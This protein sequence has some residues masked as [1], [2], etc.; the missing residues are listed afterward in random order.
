MR[1]GEVPEWKKQKVEEVKQ[2]VKDKKVVGVFSLQ[3]LP[4]SQ[5]QSIRKQL[6]G[7]A[8]L[9]VTKKIFMQR[10]F[11]EL[12]RPDLEKLLQYLQGPCGLIV[13]EENPFKLF[14]IIKKSRSKAFAKPGMIAEEDIIVP[15]GETDLPVGPVLSE[16]K[17]AKIDCKIDK[18]KIVVNKDSVVTKKGEKVTEQAAAALSKLGIMPFKIGLKILALTEDGVIYTPEVLDINEEQVMSELVSSCTKAFNLA[19]NS[20]YPTKQTIELMITQAFDKARNL[21]VNAGVFTKESIEFMLAKAAAQAAGL[22]NIT[23]G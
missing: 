15:A 9:L 23:G 10:A 11:K 1:Q 12:G 8:E 2:F 17:M 18:G 5:F 13:S 6:R 16:L 4:S 21:A 19:F 22:K 20:G 7:K 3:N 14:K